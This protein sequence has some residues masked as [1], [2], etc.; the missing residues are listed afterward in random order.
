MS[1]PLL[2][3]SLNPGVTRGLDG[4]SFHGR[5]SFT[6]TCGDCENNHYY[7]KSE[8]LRLR[9][10]P[11]EWADKVA[12]SMCPQVCE[13]WGWPQMEPC[14]GSWVTAGVG[15]GEEGGWGWGRLAAGALRGV[16]CR[17][18]EPCGHT[19]PS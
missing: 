16:L 11:E 2:S 15:P 7:Y 10:S 4:V 13:G 17:W 1:A 14:R 5:C 9:K 18:M 3:I 6:G 12:A 19:G 8:G